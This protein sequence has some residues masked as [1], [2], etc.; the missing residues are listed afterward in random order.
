MA[1]LQ[2]MAFQCMKISETRLFRQKGFYGQSK[3]LERTKSLTFAIVS[4]LMVLMEIVTC[5]ISG[6]TC[7][8]D[9]W[10]QPLNIRIQGQRIACVPNGHGDPSGW[11]LLDWH[12]WRAG[13]VF[14][15]LCVFW[16]GR[17]FFLTRPSIG[18]RDLERDTPLP[19]PSASFSLCSSFFYFSCYDCCSFVAAAPTNTTTS[20]YQGNDVGFCGPRSAYLW[21]PYCLVFF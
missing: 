15:F 19:R 8:P 3:W 11:L 18:L 12:R 4:P 1:K 16:V 7:A 17:Q 21:M 10:V 6:G 2:S 9:A 14:R 13:L 5:L 20:C